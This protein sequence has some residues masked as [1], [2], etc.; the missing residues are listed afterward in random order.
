MHFEVTTFYFRMV[1][2]RKRRADFERFVPVIESRITK[3]LFQ[4]HKCLLKSCE[5]G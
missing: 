5:D 1:S 3:L 4:M 2:L